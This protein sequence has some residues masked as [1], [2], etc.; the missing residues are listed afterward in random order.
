MITISEELLRLIKQ[1]GSVSR[2]VTEATYRVFS[3]I[4]ELIPQVEKALKANINAVDDRLKIAYTDRGEFEVEIKVADDVII[5]IMHTNSFVFDPSHPV[6]K[7][8]YVSQD[9]SR[10]NCGM[11]SVYNFLS[12]SFQFD[13]RGDRGQLSARM[14]VGKDEHFF[15][16]GKR[17]LGI[18]FNDYANTKA[19]KEMMQS[20]IESCIIYSF[21]IDVQVPP[22][23][24]M[25]EISVNDAIE[26]TMQSAM[27]I[28]KRLGFKFSNSTDE[29]PKS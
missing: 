25:R 14:F 22:V 24:A 21:D 29:D 11:I 23:E 19:S 2:D 12:D 5:F 15:V 6:L 17:Q 20:F 13:R 10:G 7:T 1:K 28:G 4:K 27:S 3:L 9:S 26:Y 8:G 18:L 16:E